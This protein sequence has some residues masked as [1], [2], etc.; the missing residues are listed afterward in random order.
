[1]LT[2]EQTRKVRGVVVQL[3]QRQVNWHKL[4]ELV[5]DLHGLTT[6]D[7]QLVRDTLATELP[8][9]DVSKQASSRTDS[10]MRQQFIDTLARLIGPFVDPAQAGV[11]ELPGRPID[12]WVFIEIGAPEARRHVLPDP[13][14]ANLVSFAESYWSTRV[15]V[16][17]NDRTVLGL[18]DHQRYW[19]LTEARSLAMDWLQSEPMAEV[20]VAPTGDQT[21]VSPA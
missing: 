11:R 18:L 14:L 7:R 3:Q 21:R 8:F 20:R 13:D 10:V 12:G 19:T 9:T 17:L 16:R 5:Y 2:S 1:M 15:T 6:A 4:D